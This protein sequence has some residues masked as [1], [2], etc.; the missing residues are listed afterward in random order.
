MNRS[1]VLTGLVLATLGGGIAQAQPAVPPFM[2]SPPVATADY[3]VPKQAGTIMVRL[4]AIG[5]VPETM[6]SSVS[7]IG[8]GVNVTATPAPEIDFS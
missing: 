7:G 4:R 5:V 3:F 6:S 1:S 2:A 8:G